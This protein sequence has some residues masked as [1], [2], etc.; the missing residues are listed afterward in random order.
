[1]SWDNYLNETEE[2]AKNSGGGDFVRLGSGEKIELIFLTPGV[3]YTDARFGKSK[4][5]FAIFDVKAKVVRVLDMSTFF[6]GSW[7]G[8]LREYGPMYRYTLTR[9][10]A[11]AN[12]TKYTLFP[13]KDGALDAKR[14]AFIEQLEHP[15]LAA[16]VARKTGDANTPGSSSYIPGPEVEPPIS[17]EDIPF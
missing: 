17:D 8:L 7:V 5:L 10:G 12:D 2:R 16:I 14:T 4:E 13:C 9:T 3:P 1:M 11:G 15:D 6:V